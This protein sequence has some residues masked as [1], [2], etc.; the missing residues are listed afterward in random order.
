MLRNANEEVKLLGCY[1]ASFQLSPTLRS[2]SLQSFTKYLNK[3]LEQNGYWYVGPLLKQITKIFQ[4][5]L[6]GNSLFSVWPL[7]VGYETSYYCL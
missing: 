6:L 1:G 4:N 5:K 2:F 3:R 7:H